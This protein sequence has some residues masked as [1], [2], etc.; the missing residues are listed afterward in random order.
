MQLCICPTAWVSSLNS[1][2]IDSFAFAWVRQM[3]T[4]RISRA[5]EFPEKCILK[6]M[7]V[8]NKMC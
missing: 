1:N 6:D 4:Q 5:R 7:K 8:N 3:F 2:M